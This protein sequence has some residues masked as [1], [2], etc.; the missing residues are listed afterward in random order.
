VEQDNSHALVGED[1]YDGYTLAPM[2]Q[3]CRTTP[4]HQTHSW[5]HGA[6]EHEEHSRRRAHMDHACALMCRT[7]CS[8]GRRTGR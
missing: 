1:M 6:Q 5:G 2:G 3:I 7:R 4:P 8:T